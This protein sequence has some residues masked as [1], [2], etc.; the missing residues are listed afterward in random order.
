MNKAWL[1]MCKWK[2]RSWQSGGGGI[3]AMDEHM[4]DGLHRRV[5]LW[6]Q[7]ASPDALVAWKV[8]QGVPLPRSTSFEI[9]AHRPVLPSAPLV[10]WVSRS[11]LH[12]YERQLIPRVLRA[13]GFVRGGSADAHILVAKL[14]AEKASKWG[15][16]V[17]LLNA[18]LSD[19]FGSITILSSGGRWSAAWGPQQAKLS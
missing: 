14:A 4:V 11:L 19:A 12:K 3:R 8:T 1:A 17:W 13:E 9:E 6:L 5:N 18:G 16:R 2:Y 15:E 10:V 7:D